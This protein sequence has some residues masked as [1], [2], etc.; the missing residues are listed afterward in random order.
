MTFSPEGPRY[1]GGRYVTVLAARRGGKA[2]HHPEHIVIVE[3]AIGHELRATAPVHHVNGDTHDNRNENLVACDSAAY[4]K[5]LH[6]R[7]DALLA[8]GDPSARRC[9]RCGTYERQGEIVTSGRQAYHRSCHA[10][11]IREANRALI[12]ATGHGTKWHARNGS[13]A[14]ARASLERAC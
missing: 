2:R 9:C 4:H 5:L 11:Q 1:A 3:R 12:A 6:T 13:L 8:C 14:E 7:T 10:E